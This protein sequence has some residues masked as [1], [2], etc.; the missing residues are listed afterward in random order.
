MAQCLGSNLAKFVARVLHTACPFAERERQTGL[1][2]LQCQLASMKFMFHL[3]E[4]C[5]SFLAGLYLFSKLAMHSKQLQFF[6][7]EGILETILDHLAAWSI[8]THAKAFFRNVDTIPNCST[9]SLQAME[10]L[11]NPKGRVCHA[12]S[13]IC[14]LRDDDTLAHNPPFQPVLEHSLRSKTGTA[15]TATTVTNA[16]VK[17]WFSS[18]REFSTSSIFTASL[19][20]AA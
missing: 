3:V 2:K 18:A 13:D 19:Q 20:L 17:A 16:E 7:L 11:I 15:A 10:A 14:V 1:V 9:A 8:C 6:S 5:T 4:T 12:V